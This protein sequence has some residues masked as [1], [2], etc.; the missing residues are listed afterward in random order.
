MREAVEFGAACPQLS[1]SG[2]LE[3]EEDCLVLN[4][5]APVFEADAVPQGTERLPVMVFIHGGGQSVGSSEVFDGSRLAAENRVIVVAVQYRLGLLG[6]FSHPALRASAKSPEDASGNWATLDL[7]EALRWV[8]ANASVF[9]GDPERVTIFGESAGGINIYSLLLSPLAKGL[10][11]RAI[12]QSG[13]ATLFTRAQAENAHDDAD[14]GEKLSSTEVLLAHLQRDGRAVDRTSAKATLES[15]SDHEIDAYLRKKSPAELL[16][17][18]SARGVGVGGGMYVSPFVLRDGH[19][20]PDVDSKKALASGRYN[21]VPVMLGTNRDEHKLFL[22]FT[23]PH[24]RRVF[25]VPIG[26]RNLDRYNLVAEYGARLW[27][28]A[29]A[30]EPAMAMR[31]NQGPSVYGYRFDWDEEKD[32]LWIDSSR[33]LGAG[34]AVE[35]FFV[36]GG[37][38]S[39]F[40]KKWLVEDVASSEHLSAQM[41]SYW[42]HFAATGKPDRGQDGALKQWKPWTTEESSPKFMVFD[43]EAGGGLR[44]SSEALTTDDVL[45]AVAE[46]ARLPALAS[47]CEVYRTFVQW[48]D[49]VTLEEYDALEDGGCAQYPIEGRTAFD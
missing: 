28:A 40:A 9:G 24:V 41:R 46:D 48:S 16:A 12:S 7:I 31:R 25:G 45:A 5:H 18:V 29:G 21:Q 44:M 32:L 11:H 49:V 8:K 3:G 20:I 42:T 35:L 10:F 30:D 33:L 19:V 4:V 47:R 15:M 1:Q 27:K 43:S 14:P 26:F 36:F 37:T 17:I 34:H 6:W 23:S 38:R 22:A 39:E 2:E 13:F